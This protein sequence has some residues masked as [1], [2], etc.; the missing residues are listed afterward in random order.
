MKHLSVKMPIIVLGLSQLPLGSV[1]AAENSFTPYFSSGLVYDSNLL[2]IDDDFTG[3]VGGSTGRSDVLKKNLL[4]MN[5]KWHYSRQQL[6]VNAAISDNDFQR[7]STLDYKGKYLKTQ[8]N[9]QLG[10]YLNGNVG[11]T[12][13]RALASF[14]DIRGLS[15]NLRDQQNYFFNLNWLIHP[16]W[17][18][19]FSY[20][21]NDVQYEEEIQ[22]IG[23]FESDSVG[24][25]ID[26]K[27]PKQSR[28]GLMLTNEEGRYPNRTITEISTIDDGYNQNSASFNIDWKYSF[29]TSF[30]FQTAYVTREYDNVPERDYDAIDKRISMTYKPTFKTRLKMSVFEETHPRDDLQASVSENFGQSVEMAWVPTS[31]ISLKANYRWET[32]EDLDN[33]GF[34]I[35]PVDQRE[36][37]NNNFSLSLNYEPHR[38][39]DFSAGYQRVKRNSTIPFGDFDADI[40]SLTATLRM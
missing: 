31:K 30:Q 40:F 37:E 24:I 28:I 1:L 26:Y 23:D 10:N 20:L 38:S 21:G 35:G 27:T 36:D 9:W 7:F 33:P 6:Q 14:N 3:S 4:G 17:E 15:G 11:Q 34:V 8:W 39:L 5:A 25:G 13:N 18:G 2:R 12:F 32:R 29:K 22:R 19:K 16:R